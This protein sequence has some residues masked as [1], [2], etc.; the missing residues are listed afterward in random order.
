[1]WS[2]NWL[3]LLTNVWIQPSNFCLSLRPIGWGWFEWDYLWSRIRRVQE[4]LEIFIL[5][6]K[7]KSF[8]NQKSIKVKGKRLDYIISTEE[9]MHQ[10][11]K[12]ELEVAVTFLHL[13]G[14]SPHSF[15]KHES[16]SWRGDFPAPGDD[17]SSLLSETWDAYGEA[18]WLISA[19]PLTS[20]LLQM[21]PLIPKAS[22]SWR[23]AA[24]H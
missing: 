17:H 24:I 18:N 23:M 4:S 2:A 10:G 22:L 12:E 8:R 3:C 15:L 13:G 5:E 1:M 6:W 7:V 11:Q 19:T 9:R 20:I 14:F 16:P 21:N